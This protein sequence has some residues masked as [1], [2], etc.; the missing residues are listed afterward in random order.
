MSFQFLPKGFGGKCEIRPYRD[1]EG[2]TPKD[3]KE[4]SS[5][6]GGSGNP[7]LVPMTSYSVTKHQNFIKSQGITGEHYSG[8]KFNKLQGQMI[9]DYVYYELQNYF[10]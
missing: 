2:I 5:S 3:T 8:G 6:S 9:N 4:S 7:Y 1:D 10:G